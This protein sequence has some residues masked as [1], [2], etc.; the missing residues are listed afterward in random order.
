VGRDSMYRM[1]ALSAALLLLSLQASGTTV[2]E[3]SPRGYGVMRKDV[4]APGEALQQAGGGARHGGKW[5]I[6]DKVD[7]WKQRAAE[8]KNKAEGWMDKLKQAEETVDAWMDKVD[9]LQA[10]IEHLKSQAHACINATKHVS[11]GEDLNNTDEEDDTASEDSGDMDVSPGKDNNIT[12]EIDP[13]GEAL[14]QAGDVA[15]H[16]G[17][18][19]ISDKLDEWKQRA[20]EWKNMAEGWMDKAKQAEETVD[21]WMDKADA[22]QAKIEHLK[23]QAHACINATKHV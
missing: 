17:K 9:A 22:L 3:V 21:A 14:Q 7:E 1:A 4:S 2:V 10:E 23:S 19:S 5:S 11:P 16:G 20:A 13:S 8:W 18:W 6:S 15:R 12:D